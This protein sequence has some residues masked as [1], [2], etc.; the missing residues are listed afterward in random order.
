MIKLYDKKLNSIEALRQEIALKKL[1]ERNYFNNILGTDSSA[2][3]EPTGN[4]NATA[5][6]DTD[7]SAMLGVGFDVLTSKGVSNKLMALAVPAI[8]LIGRKIEKD[9]LKSFAKEFALGYLK[10][11]AL[12]LGTKAVFSFIDAR[13]EKKKED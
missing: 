7:W 11:K 8:S 12:E 6:N 13:M 4:G 3:N 1:E 10:W 9:I 5:D 2:P